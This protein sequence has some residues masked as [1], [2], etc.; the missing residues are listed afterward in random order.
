MSRLLLAFLST[1]CVPMAYEAARVKTSAKAALES[2]TLVGRV[3]DPGIGKVPYRRT[4]GRYVGCDKEPDPEGCDREQDRKAVEWREQGRKEDAEKEKQKLEQQKQ[5]LEQQKSAWVQFCA[6]L[7][8]AEEC[9]AWQKENEHAA[10]LNAAWQ[11]VRMSNIRNEWMQ[12]EVS[13]PKDIPPGC[14]EEVANNVVAKYAEALIDAKN[15]LDEIKQLLAPK[16]YYDFEDYSWWLDKTE[17]CGGPGGRGGH[18]FH[19]ATWKSYGVVEYLEKNQARETGF[20]ANYRRGATKP[21]TTYPDKASPKQLIA[22]GSD[23]DVERTLEGY[24]GTLSEEK[25]KKH[26]IT[27]GTAFGLKFAKQ[28]AYTIGYGEVD[29]Q[30]KGK[31]GGWS[32]RNA[33]VYLKCVEDQFMITHIRDGLS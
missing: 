25:L 31:L 28:T 4:V 24:L 16:S 15:G 12:Q 32:K 11:K 8:A 21:A 27:Q 2:G 13:S 5:K 9:A 22:R 20:W 17:L 14:T 7:N 33:H 3:A 10:W 19:G 1:S 26:H 18:C 29:F 23:A 6:S 30:T